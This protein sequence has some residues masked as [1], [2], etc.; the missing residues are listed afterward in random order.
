MKLRN[1]LASCYHQYLKSYYTIIGL[2]S[3]KRLAEIKYSQNLK[4]KKIN[5][6][7]PMDLNEKINWLKFY[8]DTSMWP[9][10]ADKYRVREYIEQKGLSDSLNELYGVWDNADDINFDALPQSFVLKSNNGC[11]T[12]EF[13]RDKSRLD[14]TATRRMLKKWL[15]MKF[16]LLTAEPHYLKIKP[17]IIAEALLC[18]PLKTTL[19]DDYKVFC[20]NGNPYHILFCYDRKGAGQPAKYTIYDTKWMIHH[21]KILIHEGTDPQPEPKILDKMLKYSKILATNIPCVR[22][23]WYIVDD[24]LYFGE[25]TMTSA[26]GYDNTYSEEYLFELGQQ[27]E[28]PNKY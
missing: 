17:V 25:M 27:I 15:K 20:F 8:S 18:A 13:V 11:G 28:L 22:I 9:I 7:H 1:L 10:F 26:G 12:V 24:K 4:G 5:W 19:L 2:C 16:G 21:N 23:D 3:I 14:I 6:R